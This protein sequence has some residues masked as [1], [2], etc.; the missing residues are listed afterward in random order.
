MI[1]WLNFKR[2]VSSEKGTLDCT[3]DAI[4]VQSYHLLDTTCKQNSNDP[5]NNFKS[6]IP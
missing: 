6:M 4:Q 3:F 1:L 2:S 5:N